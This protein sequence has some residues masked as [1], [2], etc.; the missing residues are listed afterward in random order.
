MRVAFLYNEASE[1]PAG[2]AEDSDPERSP[3]VAAL[4][5]L[6]ND[7]TPIACTLDLDAVRGQLERLSP[8]VVF[9]RVESLGGGFDPATAP[10]VPLDANEPT[11]CEL[12]LPSPG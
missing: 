4:R 7:V 12:G 3:V 11:S 1:D 2:L 5:R 9:N 6:G 8:D 10:L